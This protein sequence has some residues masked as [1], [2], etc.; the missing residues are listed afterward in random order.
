MTWK[1][2]LQ[3]KQ[4]TK[5]QFASNIFKNRV[6]M[7]YLRDIATSKFS[8]KRIFS[9]TKVDPA[10][11]TILKFVYCLYSLVANGS[12]ASTSFKHEEQSTLKRKA[13]IDDG[14][15]KVAKKQ[16]TNSNGKFM[17]TVS[18][19]ILCHIHWMFGLSTSMSICNTIVI[20]CRCSN[21]PK[22]YYQSI[23]MNFQYAMTMK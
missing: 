9:S 14:R 8:W 15:K 22:E 12:R 7:L 1:L 5:I 20:T 2:N 4:E 23:L 17:Y 16:F 6:L 10:K 11:Q 13:V 18:N 19:S 21:I 3:S